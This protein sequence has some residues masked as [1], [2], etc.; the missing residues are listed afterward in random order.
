[1]S[2]NN[3]VSAQKSHKPNSSSAC[4]EKSGNNH[5]GVWVVET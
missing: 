4:S 5:L 1:M 3:T 2:S